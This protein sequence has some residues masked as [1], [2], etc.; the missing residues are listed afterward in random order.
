MHA[1]SVCYGTTPHDMIH[2]L[3]QPARIGGCS[4]SPLGAR[5][6]KLMD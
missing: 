3:V 5:S 4:E 6:Y 2:R 1:R